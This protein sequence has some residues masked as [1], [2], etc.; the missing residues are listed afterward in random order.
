[1]LGSYQDSFQL[2]ERN[3]DAGERRPMEQ[4]VILKGLGGQINR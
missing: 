2:L 1:V 4:L 3:K